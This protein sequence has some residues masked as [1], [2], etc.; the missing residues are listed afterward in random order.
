MI[1][2]IL[3]ILILSVTAVVWTTDV[4]AVRSRKDYFLNPQ[5]GLWFGP[6]TPVYTT[7]EVLE[8][9]LGAGG[10]FRYNTPLRSLKIGVDSSYQSYESQGVN[11][12]RMIPVYGNL[13][14][15]LPFD[16]PVKLQV[17]AGLGGANVYIEPEEFS[18]W[19][20]LGMTGI[21]LSFPAGRFVNIGLRIDYLLV[22]EG[23]AEGARKNGH[24]IN[25]GIS[26]YFN[27]NL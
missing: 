11:K 4:F 23:Y 5:V 27:L 6:I 2:R 18:Q 22:Y 21:E 15:L 10:F 26:V 14:Y 7:A 8:P 12:M 17:K 19:D 9:Y 25:A 20:P 1:K 24:I 13:I 16:L 3:I